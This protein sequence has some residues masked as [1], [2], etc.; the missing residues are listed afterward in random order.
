[1]GSLSVAPMTNAW[2]GGPPGRPACST[3]S[4][5]PTTWTGRIV[6]R[7]DEICDDTM[8]LPYIQIRVKLLRKK[9]GLPAFVR[10][11]QVSGSTP[12]P[13][14]FFRVKVS[15]ACKVGHYKT[16]VKSLYRWDA[17][18]PWT[19]YQRWFISGLTD[20]DRADVR[21]CRSTPSKRGGG[22]S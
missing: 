2:A 18:D 1:M 12:T 11:A 5:N 14:V 19:L 16:A 22:S 13:R 4:L 20:I 17:T 6:A 10:I 9:I 15:R 8:Q 3:S 21:R 7:G